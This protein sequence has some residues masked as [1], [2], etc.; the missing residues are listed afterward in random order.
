[1]AYVISKYIQLYTNVA[2][3]LSLSLTFGRADWHDFN[4]DFILLVIQ[5]RGHCLMMYV[6][7]K[8]PSLLFNSF[9]K[10]DKSDC[11]YVASFERYVGCMCKRN[12][13]F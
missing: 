11:I 5:S 8:E 13:D 2:H 6:T 4:M 9:R 7:F 10:V 12:F 1:M 3:I